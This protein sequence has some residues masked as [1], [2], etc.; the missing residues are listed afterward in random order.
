MGSQIG[1]GQLGERQSELE[2]WQGKQGKGQGKLRLER[3]RER[4]V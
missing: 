4:A 1:Q 2:E 3:K